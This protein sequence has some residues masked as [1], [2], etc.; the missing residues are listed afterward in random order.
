M[1]NAVGNRMIAAGVLC[2]AFG[3]SVFLLMPIYVGVLEHTMQLGEADLGLLASSDLIGIALVSFLAPLWINRVPWRLTV[4]VSYG[5]LIAAN[6]ASLLI[7]DFAS[8][9]T[10][11]L[12]AGALTGALSCVVLGM[13]SHTRSPD[14]M[15][16]LIVLAQVSYQAIAFLI[17]PGFIA[18]HGLSAFMLPVVALQLVALGSV[19]WFPRQPITASSDAAIADVGKGAKPWVAVL[20]LASMA[21]FFTAQASLW[22]FI[23]LIGNNLGLDDTAVGY[24]LA[25]STFIALAGPAWCAW[26]GDQFGRA[27][28][29]LVAGVAQIIALACLNTASEVWFFTAVLTVFQVFWTLALGYQ[30][31]ALVKADH[32]NRFVAVVPGSQCIGIALGP[33]LGGIVLEAHGNTGLYLVCGS[34]LL[35]Y[36]LLILPAIKATP[37]PAET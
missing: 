19:I 11:R 21:A 4:A 17:L 35:I 23:Q 25:I 24:A 18:E 31:G 29:I 3:L 28:P 22:A 15:A 16:A 14:K 1:Q 30:Y 13:F 9:F 20:I 5:G 27:R 34:A 26:A 37:E 33:A 32:S 6:L 7:D 8:L 36:L 12:L 10:L 2:M